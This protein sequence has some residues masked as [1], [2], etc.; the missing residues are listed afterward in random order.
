MYKK[1]EKLITIKYK[2]KQ[3]QKITLYGFLGGGGHIIYSA[4][5][6]C[7]ILK[8]LIAGLMQLKA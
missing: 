3:S 5:L 1:A 4:K 7:C 6:R 8:Y 2:L